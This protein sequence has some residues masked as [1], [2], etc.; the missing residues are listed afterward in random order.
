[1]HIDDGLVHGA[2]CTL[3]VDCY[4]VLVTWCSVHNDGGLD[5]GA[6]CKLMMDLC[7]VLGT[8]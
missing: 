8:H 5:Y 6:W 2:Q 3:K 1:M 7:M 4:M